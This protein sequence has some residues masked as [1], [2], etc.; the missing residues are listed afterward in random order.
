MAAFGRHSN[1]S[2]GSIQSPTRPSWLTNGTCSAREK[3]IIHD[4]R[5]SKRNSIALPLNM[6]HKLQ[7]YLYLTTYHAMKTCGE[8]SDWLH[9]PAAYTRGKE[10]RYL[11]DRRL[12]ESQS[13]SWGCTEE[14]SVALAGNELLTF[15]E[16]FRS[17]AT[18]GISRKMQLHVW[19][20][21]NL[22]REAVKV[23]RILSS[24]YIW[25][26]GFDIVLIG[27]GE[28]LFLFSKLRYFVIT[29]CGDPKLCLALETHHASAAHLTSELQCWNITSLHLSLLLW[30]E[31]RAKRGW[32][33]MRRKLLH[34][35]IVAYFCLEAR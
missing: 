21:F 11:L 3:T 13:Q 17:F 24:R 34:M 27:R 8:D 33:W 18:G 1:E 29:M 35:S 6:G 20:M 32:E 16:F 12:N 28:F 26:G 31:G 23:P 14:T 9:A 15:R 5:N 19:K 22:W 25:H 30:L 2:P 10:P 7:P 4:E